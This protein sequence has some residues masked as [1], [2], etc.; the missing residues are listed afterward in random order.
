[1]LRACASLHQYPFSL[2]SQEND[3]RG[4]IFSKI[5]LQNNGVR[6]KEAIIHL[7]SFCAIVHKRNLRTHLAQKKSQNPPWSNKRY[8]WHTVQKY[9]VWRA[10]RPPFLSRL[11]V[12]IRVRSKKVQHHPVLTRTAVLLCRSWFGLLKVGQMSVISHTTVQNL[13]IMHIRS[14][15]QKI[16]DHPVPAESALLICHSQSN[17]HVSK[18]SARL[19]C[20]CIVYGS[21]LGNSTPSRLRSTCSL[22][23][24]VSF[25]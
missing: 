13:C 6:L 5:I 11:F 8:V 16:Q 23:L 20:L 22:S 21:R 2:S 12:L 17:V 4:S 1:M 7:T 19:Q 24:D 18:P 3:I 25:F 10:H 9:L 15:E 14:P